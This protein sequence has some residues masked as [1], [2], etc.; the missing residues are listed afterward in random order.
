MSEAKI[1]DNE[2]VDK[3]GRVIKLREINGKLRIALYRALGAKDSVNTAVIGEFWPVIAV[4]SIDGRE[5]PM[6]IA[7]DVEKTYDMLEEGNAFGLIDEWL[8]KKMDARDEAEKET[9]NLK[10]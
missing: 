10:K 4:Q 1:N 3:L 9:K 2:I 7:S 5:C 8:V 6:K